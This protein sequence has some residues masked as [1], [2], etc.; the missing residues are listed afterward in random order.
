MKFK[1]QNEENKNGLLFTDR[2]LYFKK[3]LTYLPLLVT[4]GRVQNEE[5]TLVLLLRNS[6]D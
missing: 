2:Y 5:E 6:K 3:L 1:M 4:K